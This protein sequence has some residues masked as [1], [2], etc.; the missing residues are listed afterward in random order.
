M[1]WRPCS[2][3]ESPKYQ[4]T[5]EDLNQLYHQNNEVEGPWFL[6]VERRFKSSFQIGEAPPKYSSIRPRTYQMSSETE[7]SD[8][9]ELKIISRSTNYDGM[10]FEFQSSCQ[11]LDSGNLQVNPSS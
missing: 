4:L 5:E 11:P 6:R 9:Q 1:V 3:R 2:S 10:I 7:E 8:V